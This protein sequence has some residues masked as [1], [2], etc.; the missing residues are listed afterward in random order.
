MRDWILS[1]T[2]FMGFVFFSANLLEIMDALK[3]KPVKVHAFL[4]CF[5]G[6]L[7]NLG[8]GACSSLREYLEDRKKD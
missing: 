2:L 4:I 1:F 7:L 8:Y 3:I 5:V 6:I